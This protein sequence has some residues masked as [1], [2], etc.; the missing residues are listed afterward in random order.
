[1]VAQIMK[2]LH[3]SDQMELYAQFKTKK[4][5]FN[6]KLI[7]KE[8]KEFTIQNKNFN[9]IFYRGNRININTLILIY[10]IF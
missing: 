8:A 6:R 5:T 3:F 7:Y 2:I 4:M 9:L 1:M 10:N